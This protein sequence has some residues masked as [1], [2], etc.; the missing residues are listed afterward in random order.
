MEG[1]QFCGVVH[2]GLSCPQWVRGAWDCRCW[3]VRWI[4]GGR[5]PL[6]ILFHGV[7]VLAGRPLPPT[8]PR[9]GLPTA[10]LRGLLAGGA[11]QQ[12]GHLFGIFGGLARDLF[13]G[14]AC[15]PIDHPPGYHTA[16]RG[17]H[18]A[19]SLSQDFLGPS[20]RR[21]R[22]SPGRRDGRQLVVWACARLGRGL[23]PA[24]GVGFAP[25][26]AGGRCDEGV[27]HR[28]QRNE[29]V[30]HRAQGD[31]GV[32][33]LSLMRATPGWQAGPGRGPCGPVLCAG[34]GCCP[35]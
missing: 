35:S 33:R 1:R 10:A 5:R 17:P 20:T 32:L 24:R 25:G 18:S 4:S 21:D 19:M 11:G 12:D 3:P 26:L 31:E 27:L 23:A 16:P 2:R 29:G 28:A 9:S 6:L 30:L 22:A 34:T 7:L 13:G 14:A 15:H 8:A